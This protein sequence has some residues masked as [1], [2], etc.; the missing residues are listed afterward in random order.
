MA[1]TSSLR[2][3]LFL[4]FGV[5]F[6]GA[7]IFAALGVVLLLPLLSTPR[8][9]T[10]YVFLLLLGDLAVL[11]LFT[12][13]LLKRSLLA[14]LDGVVGDVRRMA[15]GDYRHRIAP[16]EA[17]EL[18]ALSE[19]VNAMAERLISDQKLLEENVRSL[20]ETNRELI[21]AR[22]QVVR[23]ERLASVGTLAAG[24]AHEVG[25]P[26]GAILGYLDVA[27]RRAGLGND[28]SDVLEAAHDEVRRI[29]R[30][31]RGVLDY[32]RPR[33]E[34]SGTVHP[35]AVVRQVRDLMTAQGRLE[36]IEVTWNLEE[37][38]SFVPGDAPHLEQVLVNLLINAVHAVEGV[39]SPAIWL[40]LRE[41]E[42][43]WLAVPVRREGDPPGVNYAH[44]RR[45]AADQRMDGA[46][47]LDSADHIVVIEIS[48]NGP[49]IPS[50]ELDRIFDPF[51]TTKAP[52][53][54]TGLG[55]AVCARLV[56]EMGGSLDAEN[57]GEGGARF[58]V[59]IPG[60]PS[61][62]G[63]PG[64]QTSE[65]SRPAPANVE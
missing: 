6:T 18:L 60:V 8:E 42:G 12:G 13:G 50:S 55:L 46:G 53:K 32:A 57:R 26:L 7:L 36:G 34:L 4:A 17:Q 28:V 31:I 39:A 51:F 1:G 21:R 58:T 25:N 54:G 49:G 10:L 20:E 64:P 65:V 9:A 15:D 56:E 47:A 35:A 40:C 43:G 63:A 22:D 61:S 29:D 27:R 23:A 37:V 5:L 62:V 44:R 41:E 33:G 16:A 45:V 2:R 52:G 3:E 38:S 11:F 14:P 30:I 24:L 59:R 19:S 48:D